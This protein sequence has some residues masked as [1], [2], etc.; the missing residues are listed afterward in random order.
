MFC[1]GDGRGGVVSIHRNAM[2]GGS[3]SV[4]TGSDDSSV[5]H[6]GICR[7]HMTG[8]RQRV[9]PDSEMTA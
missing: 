8:N 7:D 2:D 9:S 6:H 4:G 1:K 5:D 3:T